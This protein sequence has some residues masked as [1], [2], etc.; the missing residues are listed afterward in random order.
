MPFAFCRTLKLKTRTD[1]GRA[2]RHAK[3]LDETAH[4]RRRPNA[5]LRCATL[6]LDTSDIELHPVGSP[7][8]D[9]PAAFDAHL[10]STGASLRKNAHM[11]LH[12]IVGVS[13]EWVAETGDP[14]DPDN[15]RVLALMRSACTWADRALGGVWAVR[16]DLDEAGSSVVDVFASPVRANKRSGR[17]WVSTSKALE[18]M[19]KAIGRE[20]AKTYSA[21]QDSW[22][23][24]AR[25]DLDPDMKRGEPVKETRREHLRPEEYAAMQDD[26]NQ[27]EQDRRS[28]CEAAKE[29]Q[30]GRRALESD[31]DTFGAETAALGRE[32]ARMTD[33]AN[34]VERQVREVLDL[35]G[36]RV[37]LTGGL[38]ARSAFSRLLQNEGEPR[39]ER[40]ERIE[41]AS[42]LG[43]IRLGDRLGRTRVVEWWQ[44]RR[45]IQ[46]RHERDRERER[47]GVGLR[48]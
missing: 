11:A 26:L 24:A 35:L 39:D 27:I 37:F 42:R 9:L 31:R 5:T 33:R 23:A 32:R 1:I 30:L 17:P 18:E 20:G 19:A 40:I 7:T 22:A 16:Y 48:S 4:T 25:R 36:K 3:A 44:S 6:N 41:R 29:V 43:R 47:A 21:M 46:W 15:P 38:T 8:I 10:Q 13:P 14:H 28:V 2:S 34:R 45:E 12:M